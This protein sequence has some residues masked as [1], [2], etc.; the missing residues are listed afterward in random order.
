MT[1]IELSAAVLAAVSACLE[2]GDFGGTVPVEAVI[3]RP[4]NRE[5]GDYATNIA[6][7]LAKAA[8]KP[9]REI[10]E[11]IAT[12]LRGA[13]GVARVQAAGPG[14]LNITLAADSLGS[15]ARD[16]VEAGAG[17]GR[18]DTLAGQRVNLEFVSANPTGPVHLG[19]TRWAA[20]GD[21]LRRLLAAS[22]ADVTA[23]HYI[24][25]YG[26]QLDKFAASLYAAARGRQI[27]EGGYHGDYINEVALRLVA[28]HPDLMSKPEPD[29]IAGFRETGFALMVDDIRASLLRFRVK[30]DVW[31][32]E[33]GMHESGQV[34]AALVRLREQGHVYDSDGAVW[35]RT[36]DFGDD[37]D[38]VLVRGNG[39]KTYFAADA[40]YYLDKRRRGF[41]R[42]V[43]ML[44]A[45]HH[46]YVGRLRAIVACAGDDPDATLVVLIGQMVKLVQ[47]GVELRLSKRAGT[48]FTLDE[49]IDL[50]GVDAARYSL[51][52]WSTDTPLTLDVGEITKKS[53]ENP[54]FYVQ[55]AHAR[56]CSLQRNAAELGIVR[57]PEV[58]LGLLTDDREAD[59]LGALG[60]F[61]QVV[62]SAAELRAPH[63]VAHYLERLAATYHRFYD[64]NRVLPQGDEPATG[65]TDARLWL[66]EATRV[67]LANGLGLLGVSAPERL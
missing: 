11:A 34:D 15:M 60:E 49:F 57:S 44:G 65:L 30:F 61:P 10:A 66:C 20:L 45:D 62:A 50:V 12:R 63:R 39:E 5:H 13:E 48:I 21:S 53:S 28:A 2:A 35:L 38:R 58:D 8:G 6:M 4:K 40:A 18:S 31:F 55:Y 25:D 17:Y 26:S 37:K 32:S 64:A 22:G 9:P 54:V 59:L 41:D 67:V 14:F 46:G 27:P 36:T 7:R 1:P 16:I 43:Y 23:E 3:E 56:L 51:A 33:R 24:N 42:C 52:R 29:A 47:D 19:H